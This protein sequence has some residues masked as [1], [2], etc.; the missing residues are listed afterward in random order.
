MGASFG[1]QGVQVRLALTKKKSLSSI[2][3]FELKKDQEIRRRLSETHVEDFI[4]ACPRGAPE[5]G[6]NSQPKTNISY[7]VYHFVTFL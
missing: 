1:L 2:Q 7:F 6:A 4:S 5:S 3:K